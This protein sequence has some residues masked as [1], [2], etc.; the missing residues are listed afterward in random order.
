MKRSK[1][2]EVVALLLAALVAGPLP[3]QTCGDSVRSAGEQCDDG[4]TLN[5]DGCSAT[6][7]FEQ[8]LRINSL[9]L[10]RLTETACT[11]NAFGGAFTLTGHD[12]A[13]AGIDASV[14]DGTISILLQTI[15]LED[16]SGT[17]DPALSVGVLDGTPLLS[18]TSAYDGTSD[19]DWWYLAD[20]AD[21][22]GQGQ[23]LR[24][25]AGSI[26]AGSLTA[27]P[28]A[29]VLTIPFGVPASLSMSSLTV[30]ATV[31]ASTTPA[32]S[33]GE[34]PGHLADEN[35]DPALQSFATVGDATTGVLCGNVSALSLSQAPIPE[36]MVGSTCNGRYTSANSLLDL[37]VRGCSNVIF[38]VILP[39]QPDQNDP[40]A[41]PAGTGPPYTLVYDAATSRVTGCRDSSDTF[42]DLVTCLT[43]AAYSSFFKFSADRVEVLK[44]RRMLQS[45]FETGNLSGWSGRS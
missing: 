9:K 1:R 16:L 10:Q 13:Q 2:S 39:T 23:A 40:A 19:L 5:L 11:A 14:Q 34:P 31:G 45:G 15:G 27:G 43:D 33:A 28:G 25:L 35:L 12:S 41:P 29:A 37:F 26:A 17:S 36:G 38:F 21:V 7:T 4:N 24:Q 32:I 6:C 8:T 44:E 3:A 18:S 42:V 20:A 22:D 30:N